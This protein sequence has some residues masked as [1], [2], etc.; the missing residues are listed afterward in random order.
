MALSWKLQSSSWKVK[1][2]WSISGKCS[3][4]TIVN[5]SLLWLFYFTFAEYCYTPA[6]YGSIISFQE[7]NMRPDHF[8]SLRLRHTRDRIIYVDRI[9][10]RQLEHLCWYKELV[11]EILWLVPHC[12]NDPTPSFFSTAK[13]ELAKIFE[14]CNHHH[15]HQFSP[16][17]STELYQIVLHYKY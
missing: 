6:Q 11:G 16:R 1:T 17:L 2:C 7:S 8:Q 15:H 5:N 3:K 10:I 13:H 9:S 4:R 12:R 14:F